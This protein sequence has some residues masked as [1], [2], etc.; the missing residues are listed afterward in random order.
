MSWVST[1]CFFLSVIFMFLCDVCVFV[2]CGVV[3]SV[4]IQKYIEAQ[5]K[6]HTLIFRLCLPC[7]CQGLTQGSGF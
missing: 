1:C 4:C 7:F 3:A 2:L 6:L 5:D